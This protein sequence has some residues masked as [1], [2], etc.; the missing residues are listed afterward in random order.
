MHKQPSRADETRQNHL[1]NGNSQLPLELSN[2]EGHTWKLSPS[3]F[4]FLWEECKRCFYLKGVHRF[5]RPWSPMPKIFNKIDLTMKI[6]FTGKGTWV[7]APDLPTGIVEHGEKWVESMPIE[8]P[9]YTSKC[10]IRGKFDS[11]VK[12]VDGSYGVIDFKTSERK[13][14]HIP[15]YTRQLHAYAYALENAAPKHLHLSPVS[16][17]GFL[18]VEPEKM[19]NLGELAN[20]AYAYKAAL[21]W[22]ECPRNDEMFLDFLG[23][24]LDILERPKPPEGSAACEWCQYRDTSRRVLL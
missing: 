8:L 10:I 1:H 5:N 15:L 20:G 14:E 24:V 7:I 11:V 2:P 9:G 6:Y 19:M 4:A 3:D 13:S 23:E 16:K 12:F 21:T 18:C 17:P 22:M